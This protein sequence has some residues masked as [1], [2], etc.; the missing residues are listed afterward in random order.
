MTVQEGPGGIKTRIIKTSYPVEEGLTA[1][2]TK[3]YTDSPYLEA[4]EGSVVSQ[5]EQAGL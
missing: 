2:T 5:R 4:E 3:Q 1:G